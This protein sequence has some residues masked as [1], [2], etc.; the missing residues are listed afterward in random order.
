MGTAKTIIMIMQKL[1][2]TIE[3]QYCFSAHQCVFSIS[4]SLGNSL[5]KHCFFFP[6]SK[7]LTE[8]IINNA[9]KVQKYEFEMCSSLPVMLK[10]F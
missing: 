4:S 10:L 6:L 2:V 9:S 3:K 1:I 5:W 7:N 8:E